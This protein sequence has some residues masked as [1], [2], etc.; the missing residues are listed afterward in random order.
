VRSAYQTGVAGQ[1]DRLATALEGQADRLDVLGLK[2][3]AV[4]AVRTR[5][6]GVGIPLPKFL[7]PPPSKH[8]AHAVNH[9]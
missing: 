5:V 7:L 6:P 2:I 9:P 4:G 1:K 8:G 3:G